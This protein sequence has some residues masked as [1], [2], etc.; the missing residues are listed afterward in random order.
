VSGGGWKEP[1]YKVAK[2]DSRNLEWLGNAVGWQGLENEAKHNKE[3]PGRAITKA[4]EYAALYY[5][6]GAAAG[7]MGGGAAAGGGAAEAAGTTAAQAAAEQ[8]AIQGA[9]QGGYGMAADYAAGAAPEA[10][11]LLSQS[12]A[13]VTDLSL[14]TVP[15][16]DASTQAGLLDKARLA[17]SGGKGGATST[18]AGSS[19]ATQYGLGLLNQ[20]PQQAP[21]APGRPAPQASN[22][23]LHYAYGTPQ[24]NS[25][26]M[27][28]LTEEQKRK[29]R[30]QGYQI[31]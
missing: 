29:L 22:E 2:N 5:L 7:A 6:G 1:F 28:Q 20:R 14:N 26:G 31:P 9:E 11:G 17:F 12:A 13:P 16:K 27:S 10:S 4:A 24:G 30:A 3:N 19:I 25:L 15:V 21:M 23:P 8:A 18:K